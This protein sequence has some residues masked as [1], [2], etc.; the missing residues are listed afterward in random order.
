MEVLAAY[1][2]SEHA[3]ELHVFLSDAS[4]K[5]RPQR[6]PGA[7]QAWS[8]TDRLSEAQILTIVDDYLSGATAAQ[9]AAANRLS[10]SSLKRILRSAQVTKIHIGH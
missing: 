9:L 3:S 7:R 4:A 8:L 2:H 6:R 5:Q 1:S 10:L